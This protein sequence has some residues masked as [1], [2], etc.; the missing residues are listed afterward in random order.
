[1][2]QLELEVVAETF[3][4][5]FLHG[6]VDGEEEKVTPRLLVCMVI[7]YYCRVFNYFNLMIALVYTSHLDDVI[8][9]I[10][11]YFNKNFL[12]VNIS[13]KYKFPPSAFHLSCHCCH[14]VLRCPANCGTTCCTYFSWLSMLGEHHLKNR[15]GY[16]DSLLF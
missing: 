9:K 16:R 4:R 7:S 14:W 15:Q 12:R 1:M 8:L 11:I 5:C 6:G 2:G 3:N 10:E 13:D